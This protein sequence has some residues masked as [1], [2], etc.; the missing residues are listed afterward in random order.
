MLF[1]IMFNPAKRPSG[2]MKI[3]PSKRS[4]YA[5][6]VESYQYCIPESYNDPV[7]ELEKRLESSKDNTWDGIDKIMKKICSKYGI[8]PKKLHNDFKA[9]HKMIPD[10]WVKRFD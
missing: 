2:D 8:T 3:T 5:P 6:I 4:D 1:F 10:E 7:N 9:K